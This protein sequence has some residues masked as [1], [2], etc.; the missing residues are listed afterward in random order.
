MSK[1]YIKIT[2]YSL[3]YYY[4]VWKNAETVPFIDQTY[5]PHS[6]ERLHA[7]LKA[8]QHMQLSLTS[9]CHGPD[10]V[11]CDIWAGNAEEEHVKVETENDV[12]QVILALA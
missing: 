12:L 5:R 11:E 7:A 2:K 8:A 1:Y 3:G 6:I 10:I 4:A 9:C